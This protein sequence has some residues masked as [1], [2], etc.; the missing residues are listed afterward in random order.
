MVLQARQELQV[1]QEPMELTDLV[2]QPATPVQRVLQ[3][4][5]ELTV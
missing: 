1:R 3:V 4:T 2:V 5:T